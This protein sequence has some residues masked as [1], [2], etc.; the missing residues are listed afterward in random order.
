VRDCLF[1]NIVSGKVPSHRIWEDEQYLAVLDIF[2][3][4]EGQSIV[5][6]KTHMDSYL[7]SLDDNEVTG[8]MLAAKRVAL[9]LDK[10]LE[11][12]R[13]VQVMEGLGV[14]HAHVKLYPVL[15]LE[16]EGALLH[17]GQRASEKDLVKL[18][19]RIREGGMK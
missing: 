3:L 9:R 17:L 7:F 2:P 10:V 18:A 12:S 15:G 11:A 4:R 5:M 16:G 19:E 1:C 8:L 6:P 13:S 14:N